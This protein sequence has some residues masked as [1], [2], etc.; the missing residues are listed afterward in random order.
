MRAVVVHEFGPWGDLKVEEF[1]A[2]EPGPSDVL[3]DVR[4]VAINFSDRLMMEGKYQLRPERPFVPGRDAC[5]IV[6]AVGKDVTRCKPGDR[7]MA[8]IPYGAY[9]ER[10]VAPQSR[11]WVMP[12]SLSFVQGAALGNSYLTAYLGLAEA[13]RLAADSQVLI[14]GASGGVGLA[15]VEIVKGLGG[16][17]IAGVTSK[18]KGELCLRHG[19]AAWVDLSAPDLSEALR[20]QVQ[21]AT[22]GKGVDIVLDQVGGD[23]FDAALRCIA[24]GGRIVVVGFASGRIADVKTNYLLLKN[25]SVTGFNVEPFLLERPQ[26]AERAAADLFKLFEG[27]QIRPEVSATYPLEDFKTALAGFGRGKVQGKVVLTTGKQ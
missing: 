12:N 5:G 19:A 18:E 8:V 24:T 7:V 2:P 16:R 17:A 14:T 25:L 27:G 21:A 10:A 23:V 1:P 26:L 4:A 3:I 11:C 15:A 6:N 13:G 9:A 20:K 22:G